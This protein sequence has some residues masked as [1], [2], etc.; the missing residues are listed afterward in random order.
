MIQLENKK[1]FCLEQQ[2]SVNHIYI[3]KAGI[4]QKF[5]YSN[6]FPLYLSLDSINKL[7]NLP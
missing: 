7:V 5:S 3:Y 1:Q 6:N 2:I 4:M